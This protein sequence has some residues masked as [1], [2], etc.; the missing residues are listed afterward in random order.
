MGDWL[1]GWLLGWIGFFECRRLWAG[2]EALRVLPAQ[3]SVEGL[4][5][6]GSGPRP[7][8]IHLALVLYIT[9]TVFA[10]PLS[11]VC[12]SKQFRT[13]VEG[14]VKPNQ[15]IDHE[16]IMGVLCELFISGNKS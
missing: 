8:D 3:R 2:A 13:G 10:C 6:P 9:K 5:E 4:R 14:D 12:G 11:E 15:V 1:V 7:K 16:I